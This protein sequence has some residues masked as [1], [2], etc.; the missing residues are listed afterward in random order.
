RFPRNRFCYG[1]SLTDGEGEAGGFGGTALYG[2][3]LQVFGVLVILRDAVVLIEGVAAV[4]EGIDP[5]VLLIQRRNGQRRRGGR[6]EVAL[7]EEDQH[8][9]QPAGDVVPALFHHF[10]VVV[11]GRTEPEHPHLLGEV[12]VAAGGV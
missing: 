10:A 1:S 11:V 7:P 9:A 12:D 2:E 3:R 8:F 4:A 6:E 5:E